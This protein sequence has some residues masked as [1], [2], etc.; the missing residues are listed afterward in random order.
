MRTLKIIFIAAFCL[1][2]L[3]PLISTRV[4][5]L[6]E[7]IQNGSGKTKAGKTAGDTS[8]SKQKG[9]PNQPVDPSKY[10]GSDSCSECHGA[11]AT[12]YALTAHSKTKL[13]SDKVDMRGCEA[14]HGGARDH[15]GFYLNIQKLNEAG[16]EAEATTLMND[17]E[18]AAAAKMTSFKEI[19]SAEASALC[20]KC[21]EGSQGRAEE[22]FMR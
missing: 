4:A 17:T 10:V 16:K 15:V 13:I 22:R 12:H 3:S 9:T 11:E 8:Q 21:H 2:P 6:T 20:L 14:C 5:A 18:K 19:G 7:T 1:A